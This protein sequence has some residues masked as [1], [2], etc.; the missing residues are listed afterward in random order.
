MKNTLAIS[1]LFLFSIRPALA[2]GQV[3]YYQLNI[4]YIVEKYCVNKEAPKLECNGKC[5]LANKMDI[6]EEERTQENQ[7]PK[8]MLVE[9]F[10]PL[11]FQNTT[12]H[13]TYEPIAV[14]IENNWGRNQF[15]NSIFLPVLGPPPR[16]S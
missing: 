1:L 3:L 2:V 9:A 14:A 4:D 11:F 13:K 7:T 16:L 12:F 8:L 5:F 15:S 6:Q 10:F